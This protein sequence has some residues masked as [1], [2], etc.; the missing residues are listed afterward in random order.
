M[1]HKNEKPFDRLAV[2]YNVNDAVTSYFSIDDKLGHW[3]DPCF[4]AIYWNEFIVYGIPSISNENEMD[5]DLEDDLSS[6]IEIGKIVG[7][8]IAKSLIENL[9]AEPYVACDDSDAVLEEMYS[10]LQEHM[11]EELDWID[12]IYYLHDIEIKPEYQGFG[13]EVILLRQLPAV[14]VKSLQ[15]FPSLLVFLP[16]QIQYDEPESNDEMNAIIRHRLEYSWQNIHKDI[17]GDNV[18][19]FPPKHDIPEKEI[20]RLLG[21]RNPGDTVPVAYRD[22]EI[23]KLYKSA[24]FWEIGK[25]GWLC[26]II[27]NIF[28][29][30]S[31]NHK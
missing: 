10:V 3:I 29:K 5:D 9:G 15:V 31:M 11:D 17:H 2:I 16:R 12:D 20:N 27:A 23:Y 22:Q 8:H 4:D 19:L 1:I 26:K 6:G 24:G 28:T 25:T 21:R 7:C 13:Y 14:I 18:V 30:D